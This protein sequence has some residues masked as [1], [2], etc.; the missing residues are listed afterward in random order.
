MDGARRALHAIE[1]HLNIL[2]RSRK[3]RQQFS[4]G[5]LVAGPKKLREYIRYVLS[6][7]YITQSHT[8]ETMTREAR[9]MTALN[10]KL[11]LSSPVRW[12]RNPLPIISTALNADPFANLS[13]RF[14]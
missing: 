4:R 14:C 1:Q 11:D 12:Y 5:Q 3:Y 8:L 10:R 6:L 9:Y 13:L 7:S 2:T